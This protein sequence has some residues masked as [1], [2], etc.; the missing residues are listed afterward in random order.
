M[1]K[2]NISNIK[3]NNISNIGSLNIG[4]TILCNNQ[5]STV[6]Y[7]VKD[8]PYQK[9]PEVSQTTNPGEFPVPNEDPSHIAG[10][11]STRPITNSGT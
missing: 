8:A 2:I 1:Q 7:P 4:K 6:D 3:I 9:D 5:V 10:G 11:V